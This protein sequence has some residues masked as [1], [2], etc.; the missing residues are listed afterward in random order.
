MAVVATLP[1]SDEDRCYEAL[2]SRDRRF[3]GQFIAGITSTGIYCRPSCPAPVRPLRKHVRFFPT[4]A[5]AQS[6]GLRSCKRCQPD[7]SPGTPE[8]DLR[9]DLV[10]RAMRL[11]ERGEVDRIGVTGVARELHISERHLHRVLTDA[12]G[13]SPIALARAQRANLARILLQ[14]SLIHI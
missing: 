1:I 14:L 5:A 2:L 6:A 12:V 7:A 13:A 9:G 4:A 10:A 11:I 3:D 8:W